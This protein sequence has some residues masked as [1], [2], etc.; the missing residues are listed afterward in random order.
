MA[1][2]VATFNITITV[3]LFSIVPIA[4]IRFVNNQNPV[5]IIGHRRKFTQFHKW[6]MIWNFKPTGICKIAYCRKIHFPICDFPEKMFP[7][8]GADC[9]EIGSVLLVIPPLY[10]GRFNAVFVFLFCHYIIC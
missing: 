9:D 2:V 10:T 8:F 7:V 5:Y 1:V 6:E 4:T 3:V